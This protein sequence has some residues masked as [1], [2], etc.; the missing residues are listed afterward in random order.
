MNSIV[1]P[2]RCCGQLA[3]RREASAIF[4]DFFDRRLD[5]GRAFHRPITSS[6]DALSDI[7][8]VESSA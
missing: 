2:K 6:G 1:N 7:L 4:R 5:D 8:P 3:G